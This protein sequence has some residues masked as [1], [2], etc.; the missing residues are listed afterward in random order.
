MTIDKGLDEL[1]GRLKPHGEI[2]TYL[3]SAEAANDQQIELDVILGAQAR[4]ARR[5]G[6]RSSA[7]GAMVALLPRRDAGARRRAAPRRTQAAS[8]ARRAP[9]AAAPVRSPASDAGDE[10]RARAA[11]AR[12]RRATTSCR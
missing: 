9:A 4:A 1:K 8:A 5:C 6:R 3:P 7:T 2:I 10:R 12:S 11:T